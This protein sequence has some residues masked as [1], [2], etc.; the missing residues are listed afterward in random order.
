MVYSGH[1]ITATLGGLD[2]FEIFLT[3][4]S[5]LLKVMN[6]H[7]GYLKYENFFV[8]RQ[9]ATENCLIEGNPGNIDYFWLFPQLYYHWETGRAWLYQIHQV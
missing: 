1:L 6:G 7:F 8:F 2:F 4:M 5:R 3:A 9:R